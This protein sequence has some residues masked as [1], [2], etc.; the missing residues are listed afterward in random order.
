MIG[1]D[2]L[3]RGALLCPVLYRCC[4]ST[5][6]SLNR[7]RAVWTGFQGGPGVSTFYSGG[8]VDLSAAIRT[9][10]DALK[11]YLPSTVHILVQNYGDTIEDSTGALTGTWTQ[12]ASAEV[13][14]T[15]AGN[16]SGVSG[17]VCAWTTGT[18][19]NGHRVKGRT[20]IVPL[21]GS[22]YD[23][24]G[25]LNDTIT[26][27]IAAAGNT[28]AASTN[29]KIWHRPR[30]ATPSWT[31]VRGVTHAAKAAYAGGSATVTGC[32]VKDLA[33]KLSSRRQ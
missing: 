24:V 10:F 5:M 13:V 31:D 2:P 14:G 17:L 19:L 18:V 6:A 9:Y 1:I 11:T 32:T 23:A 20:F 16:Y 21:G 4:S 29:M 33:A 26:G 27:P 25:T 15:Q 28:L 7:Y 3:S 22:S 12:T 30:A 8:G